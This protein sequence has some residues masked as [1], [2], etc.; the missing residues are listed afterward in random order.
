MRSSSGGAR[1]Q[2]M[3][4]THSPFV[5]VHASVAACQQ[6]WQGRRLA[7]WMQRVGAHATKRP[8][9]TA[10]PARRAW[11]PRCGACQ[12]R[13]SPPAPAW[14][15]SMGGGRQCAWQGAAH[16]RAARPAARC[17]HARASGARLAWMVLAAWVA[18]ASSLFPSVMEAQFSASSCGGLMRPRSGPHCAARDA[19]AQALAHCTPC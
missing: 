12:P 11:R 10:V 5:T 18:S 3:L 4:S 2:L 7:R 9:S 17:K 16:P 13:H 19:H 6:R 8:P 15:S 14:R 1:R